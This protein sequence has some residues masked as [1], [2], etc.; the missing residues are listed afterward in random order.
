M[1]PLNVVVTQCVA[2]VDKT[3]SPVEN[4]T[5]DRLKVVVQYFGDITDRVSG[6]GD[7]LVDNQVSCQ[8]RHRVKPASLLDIPQA[9][10]TSDSFH[11]TGR[12][13]RS[14]K[15]HRLA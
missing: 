2:H 9:D 6:F 12:D 3:V 4:P 14:H 11:S 7:D 10:T 5:G 8:P 15:L 1:P 13:F